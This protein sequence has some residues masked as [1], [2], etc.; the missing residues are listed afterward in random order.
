M[1]HHRLNVESLLDTS[2][3][4]RKLSTILLDNDDS[5][6]TS[7]PYRNSLIPRQMAVVEERTTTQSPIL[8]R[9]EVYYPPGSR[10]PS[11]CAST[12]SSSHEAKPP[13]RRRSRSKSLQFTKNIANTVRFIFILSSMLFSMFFR[14][15]IECHTH[16]RK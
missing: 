1:T 3:L 10:R 5:T 4:R 15:Q 13:P 2:Q 6:P 14:V 12:N 11:A 7:R 9:T 8:K 16:T